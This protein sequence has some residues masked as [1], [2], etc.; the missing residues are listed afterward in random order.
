MES[1]Q[2]IYQINRERFNAL[3]IPFQEWR[4]E[5]ILDFETDIKV[6]AEL[7]WTGT[8]TKSLFLKLKGQGYAVYLTDK[9]SRLD[10][11]HIKIIT[12]KRPSICPDSE[13]IEQLG[14]MPG[15]V[16]PIGLP[17]HIIIIVDTRLYQHD[18]LLYTPG[19]P[20]STFGFAGKELKRLLL[21][22]QNTLYEI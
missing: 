3:S 21:A 18:E 14:C 11:K 10:A 1:L 7:G 15:A 22:G 17:E 20:N 2:E 13:M 16:C 5:A 4:H 12:G 8:H 6:A 9:D 19:L